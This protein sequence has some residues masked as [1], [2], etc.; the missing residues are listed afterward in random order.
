MVIIELFLLIF[1]NEIFLSQKTNT[2]LPLYVTKIWALRKIF[3]GSI[4]IN[5][6]RVL[7]EGISMG[8]CKC[9]CK[10]RENV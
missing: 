3:T 10:S 4:K 1:N 6:G 9:I 7:G 8:V 5:F 2:V